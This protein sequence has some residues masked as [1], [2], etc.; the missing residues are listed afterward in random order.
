MGAQMDQGGIHM[1]LT[2]TRKEIKMNIQVMVTQ[3][4]KFDLMKCND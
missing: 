3:K 2:T 4:V 1:A